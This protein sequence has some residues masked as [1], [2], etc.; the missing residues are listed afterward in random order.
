[1]VSGAW[2]DDMKPFV[3]TNNAQRPGSIPFEHAGDVARSYQTALTGHINSVIGLD[4]S[5]TRILQRMHRLKDEPAPAGPNRRR[6]ERFPRTPGFRGPWAPV[7][8]RTSRLLVRSDTDSL[9]S[10]D[11]HRTWNVARSLLRWCASEAIR[12]LPVLSPDQP[13]RNPRASTHEAPKDH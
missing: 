4:C 11:R 1:M 13:F 10:A 6:D 5:Q 2:D 3:F 7:P 9:G 8:P 12:S